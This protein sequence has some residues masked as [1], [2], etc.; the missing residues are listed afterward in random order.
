MKNTAQEKFCF[1]DFELDRGRRQLL[2]QGR[3]VAM[4]AR[5]F[6]L[7]L[8]LTENSGR[9]VPKEEILESIWKDQFVEESN[10]TV[11]ISAIRKVLGDSASE[12]RFL[13]T[14]PG[15]GY[16][17]VADVSRPKE[18]DA[19]P[20]LSDTDPN[21]HSG[22]RPRPVMWVAIAF[23]IVAMA[24]A[25]I[26]V[27]RSLYPAPPPVVRS[28]AVLPFVDP[29]PEGPDYIGDGL[30]ESVIFSLS[31]V[32]GLKILSSGS[33]FRYRSE[34]PD[35]AR[36]GRE[37]G[38]DAILTGRIVRTGDVISVRS[39]LVSSADDSVI[40]GDQL[41]R[42]LSDIEKLQA[43]IARSISELLRVKLTGIDELRM[44]SEQ[45]DNGEA[46][47]LYLLGKY[48]MNRLTD[49][50]FAKGRD[51]FKLAIEKDPNYALAYASLA[52]SYNT[53][54]GWGGLAP[55][56]GYPLARTAAKRSLELD[57]TLAEGYAAL[58]VVKLTYD[59]DPAGADQD[60]S[61]AIALNPNYV[62]ALQ[63]QSFLYVIQGRFDE[64]SDAIARA[65]E[66]D[67]LSILNVIMSG[68]VY[69][70][71]RQASRAVEVYSRAVEMDPNSGLAHWSLGNAYLLANNR[72]LA[73]EEYG[74][75]ISLSGTSPDERASL[76]FAY[77]AG[78]DQEQARI[79]LAE[80]ENQDG[81]V[82]PALV[83]SV[84]G[85][86]GEHD[87]AFNLLEEAFRKKDPVLLY[88]GVD[89]MFDPLRS[90][91]RYP[92]LLKRLRLGY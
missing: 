11:Q 88:L 43:D 67:P 50:G 41:S 73:I 44:G 74:K 27:V 20:E 77:A 3:P 35:A 71:Q 49:D 52:D 53:L 24:V 18:P 51:S 80:L 28:I 68:N 84:R 34:K 70:F 16:Q 22:G 85:A 58:G 45:T 8:F 91:V 63:S 46:Y 64:A 26:F 57:A 30:A 90:D 13:A 33:S 60:L 40:W 5:A 86:L 78:G 31:R 17:F 14:I 42:K 19:E 81:Y 83:A 38:V 32:P 23:G 72:D 7:L 54:C 25:L 15:K 48:H 1:E 9:I 21:S 10:L 56:E 92:V 66:L 69:Y 75:A 55:H 76:A 65:R 79:I 47:K 29:A 62:N 2:R 39:E 36:I 12:P 61:R 6:D 37:L 89:P 87:K 59:N 82:P 4:N